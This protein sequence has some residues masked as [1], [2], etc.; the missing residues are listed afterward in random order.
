MVGSAR[1]HIERQFTTPRD[2]FVNL[3]GWLTAFV[4]DT[5]KALVEYGTLLGSRQLDMGNVGSILCE[6]N[7]W[8]ALGGK[9]FLSEQHPMELC[10]VDPRGCRVNEEVSPHRLQIAKNPSEA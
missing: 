4:S 8:Q 3:I 5:T 10:R 6:P 9:D 1:P 2:G 7:P